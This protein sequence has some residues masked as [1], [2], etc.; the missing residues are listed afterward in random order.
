MLL[1]L[2]HVRVGCGHRRSAVRVVQRSDC[3]CGQRRLV[4]LRDRRRCRRNQVLVLVALLL[5]MVV[6]VVQVLLVADEVLAVQC[7]LVVVLRLELLLLCL[8]KRCGRGHC[9]LV[10]GAVRRVVD[11]LAGAELRVPERVAFVARRA[12]CLVPVILKPVR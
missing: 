4:P 11:A 5:Q 10:A 1:L 6:A 2:G 12:L 7:V 8:F 3:R 9:V